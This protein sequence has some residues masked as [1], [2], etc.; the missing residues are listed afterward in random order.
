VNVVAPELL[1]CVGEG[2]EKT[3]VVDVVPVYWNVAPL[4]RIGAG[5][6]PLGTGVLGTDPEP[7]PPHAQTA[8]PS[9]AEDTSI[10]KRVVFMRG[11]FRRYARE[12]TSGA[13]F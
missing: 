10:A 11:T 3:I 7:P 1:S 4:T 2:L 13:F 12:Q 6:E 8:A 9:K 5:G